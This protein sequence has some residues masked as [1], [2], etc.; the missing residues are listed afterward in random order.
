MKINK[1]VFNIEIPST[2]TKP[3]T[4]VSKKSLNSARSHL[5]KKNVMPPMNISE[6]FKMSATFLIRK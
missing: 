2:T 5:S 4:S 1:A 3:P 6:E